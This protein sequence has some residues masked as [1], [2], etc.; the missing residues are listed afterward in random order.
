MEV[1]S[2]EEQKEQSLDQKLAFVQNSLVDVY[3]RHKDYLESDTI[4]FEEFKKKYDFWL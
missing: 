2:D 1:Y 4:L 3:A